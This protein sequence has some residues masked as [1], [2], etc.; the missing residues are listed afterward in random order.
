VR[1]DGNTRMIISLTHSTSTNDADR[2]ERARQQAWRG[3]RTFGLFL[4]LIY[5]LE[6]EFCSGIGSSTARSCDR[7]PFALLTFFS[8]WGDS[9]AEWFC[10]LFVLVTLRTLLVTVKVA[11]VCYRAEQIAQR[12]SMWDYF[13]KYGYRHHVFD[14]KKKKRFYSEPLGLRIRL[15]RRSGDR[16]KRTLSCS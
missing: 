9:L 6:E 2:K 5:M 4:A 13:V 12:T 8:C 1:M 3:I 16:F 7:F 15:L 10:V 11:Y 14:Y